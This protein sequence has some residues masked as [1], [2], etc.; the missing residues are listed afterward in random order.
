MM[1]ERTTRLTGLSLVA[2]FG[3]M[4][5]TCDQ[6]EIGLVVTGGDFNKQHLQLQ[7]ITCFLENLVQIAGLMVLHQC[8]DIARRC[9]IF[10]VGVGGARVD[11]F[12]HYALVIFYSI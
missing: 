6:C 11:G 2:L 8:L 1:Q 9:V 4:V 3:K 10:W 7:V 12:G 5:G